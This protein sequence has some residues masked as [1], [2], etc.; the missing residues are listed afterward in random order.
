MIPAEEQERADWKAAAKDHVVNN[1]RLVAERDELEEKLGTWAAEALIRQAEV[2]DLKAE[3]E[4]AHGRWAS[5]LSV[6]AAQ[7]AKWRYPMPDI[8]EANG[9]YVWALKAKEEMGELS[10]ALL[11]G[12]HGQ[13][14]R[15]DALEE[16]R[17][18]IAVLLR[19]ATFL[20][21]SK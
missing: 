6:A 11:A 17:Q 19:V 14:G 15:G 8:D 3:L 13:P 10:A 7:D 2:R 18:L 9:G 1:A 12:I 16:C 21:G 20:E 5:I 4:K